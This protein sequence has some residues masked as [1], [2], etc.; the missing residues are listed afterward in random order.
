MEQVGGVE[1]LGADLLLALQAKED[2]VLV[3]SL[4]NGDG[5]VHLL[6]IDLRLMDRHLHNY[7]EIFVHVLLLYVFAHAQ[8]YLVDIR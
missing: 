2:E 8:I 7:V 4:A 1:A 3:V 6:L 5:L